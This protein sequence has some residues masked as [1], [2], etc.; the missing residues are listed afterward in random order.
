MSS[1]KRCDCPECGM[2]FEVPAFQKENATLKDGHKVI[3]KYFVCTKCDTKTIV[4][5][6]D[7]KSRAMRLSINNMKK[8]HAPEGEIQDLKYQLG[9]HLQYLMKKYLKEHHE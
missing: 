4:V 7:D 1:K 6:Q 5:V 9:K 3:V 8:S 2:R